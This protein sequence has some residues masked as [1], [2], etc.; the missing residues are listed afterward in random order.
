MRLSFPPAFYQAGEK[1]WGTS[2][3][4]YTLRA[5]NQSK[6]FR[7]E[8]KNF[9]ATKDTHMSI[10]NEQSTTVTLTM[11][12]KSVKQIIRILRQDAIEQDANARLL[13][14]HQYSQTIIQNEFDEAYQL[15]AAAK[16]LMRALQESREKQS[17]QTKLENKNMT[18]V[19]N[20]LTLY[21]SIAEI[22]KQ[23]DLIQLIDNAQQQINQLY[24][25]VN[26]RDAQ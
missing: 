12:E 11:E 14:D 18:L 1:V 8:H 15:R 20:A 6:K 26:K 13:I 2:P 10:N 9:H 25:T 17:S 24:E 16:Q 5:Q 3:D 23:K 4:P 22:G 21:K 19:N 7:D